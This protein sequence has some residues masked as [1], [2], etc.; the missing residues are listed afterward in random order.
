MAEILLVGSSIFQAWTC[1]GQLAPGRVVANR[2]V[3]GT[4]TGYW[5]ERLGEILAAESPD[6]ILMYC[7]SNDVS[8]GVPEQ[9][10]IEN[11]SRC[12]QVARRQSPRAAL[13][14]FG[15]IKAPEKAGKWML[16]GIANAI[17][18]NLTDNLLSLTRFSVSERA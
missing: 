18:N 10:I 8:Q 17:E 5:V 11:V 4:T 13:A 12:R 6:S 3:G 2:A 15:I 16:I 7:G 9:R 1:A 14:Y